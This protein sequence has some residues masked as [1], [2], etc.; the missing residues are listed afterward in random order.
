MSSA[1]SNQHRGEASA[2]AH[3]FAGMDRSMQQKVALTTAFFPTRGQVADMGSGSGRGTYDLACLYP[4]LTLY[5]VDIN[6]ISVE[7]SQR[8][9]QRPNLRYQAGDISDVVFPDASLDGVLDSSVLHH[10]TSFND[11]SLARLESC[12]RNQVAALRPGGVLIIRDFV[13]PDGPERV[14]L[15]LP[16]R[17]GKDNGMIPELSTAA[18]F[19][20]FACSFRSSQHRAGGVPFTRYPAPRAGRVGYELSL[21]DATEF[22]LRKDYRRD[23]ETELLEE[24]TYY[25]QAQ[26]ERALRGLGLRL[27]ASVPIHNP[28]IIEH[29][30]HGKVALFDL[31]G[32]ELPFPPTNY[33]VVGEK[34][35]PDAPIELHEVEQRELPAPR[36]FVP[37]AY[38]HTRSGRR[39]ELAGRPGRTLDIVPWF[40]RGGRVHVLAK[41]GF[42]RPLLA[43]HAKISGFI[44]EPIAAIVADDEPRSEA[45]ARILHERAAIEPAEMRGPGSLVRYFTSPG[46][47]DECVEAA[48]VELDAAALPEAT[49]ELEPNIDYGDY[50][51]SGTVRELDAA[52]L[53]R[54]AQVGGTFDAR[55]EIGA[56]RALS[57]AGQPLDGWIGAAVKLPL[58]EFALPELKP[59]SSATQ[60]TFAPDP[61]PP[62]YLRFIE[63]VF[64]ARTADGRELARATR[65]YVVP[66]NV[67]HRTAT[68]LPVARTKDGV[69]VALESRELPA[70]ERFTGNALLPVCPAFRLP[71]AV[72]S[73][74]G[75][76]DFL[77]QRCA[78]LGLIVDALIPLGGTYAPSAGAT[79]ELVIP[80]AAPIAAINADLKLEFT[81]M[82]PLYDA[83]DAVL[84]A[85]T[86]I[87]LLRLEHALRG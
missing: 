83:I 60:P 71:E 20:R 84:D 40:V 24:Y 32:G 46:G 4:G 70:V 11:F 72:W 59:A 44:T 57:A 29:R 86:K 39:L 76:E 80:F 47:L 45:V 69:F 58:R 30:Y 51:V 31:A 64:A 36:F 18:L 61:G 26:F 49:G 55:I 82:Q 3:Y 22:I 19:E 62:T 78:E 21:R 87:A 43:L 13:V 16:E 67:S 54:A 73:A 7:L 48:L 79:P 68:V 25:S 52:Q 38:R 85:H 12:L 81:P 35:D 63:G 50:G 53:L 74:P 23:W 56:Y 41:K 66:R 33:F 28:W 17:D 37:H 10:V 27:L 77:R 6:P 34:I 14:R 15:E 42:P 65:E 8:T 2:Y 5:G 1:Y 75:I 9:Y